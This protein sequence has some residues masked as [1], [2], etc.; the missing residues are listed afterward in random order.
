MNWLSAF[1][2]GLFFPILEGTLGISAMFL[3]FAV[4]CILGCYYFNSKLVETKGL[5]QNEIELIDFS[6]SQ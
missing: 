6:K 2:I 3:I 5:T 1:L 4:C